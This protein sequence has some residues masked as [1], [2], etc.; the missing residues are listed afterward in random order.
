M[1]RSDFRLTLAHQVWR[2][3]PAQYRRW[4]LTSASALL[5]PR[6]DRAPPA[7]QVGVAVAGE[8][9]RASGIGEGA[10]LML[11][12]LRQASVA[13]WAMDVG[14]LLPAHTWDITSATE[15]PPPA[16]TLVLHV[17]PPLLPLVLMR[18]P[19][20]MVRGRRIV[21]YW[22]WEL[23]SAPPDWRVGARFVH[24]AWVPSAFTAGAIEPL[25]PG[26]V[27]VVPH[28]VAAAPPVASILDRTTFGL[29]HNAVIVLVSLNLASSFERK[30]PLAA[31]AAFRSAFGDRADRILV[32]KV[33][34][35]QHFP[36]DFARIVDAASGTSNI[37]L[38]TRFLPAAD[39]HALTI[40]CDIVLSM[41]RSEGFGLMLAEAMLLGRPVVAT[42]WSGNMTFMDADC[43]ALIDY[44]LVAT[45]DPR[46]V[47]IDGI[48]AEPDLGSAIAQLR[49]LA[50]DPAARAHI[51]AKGRAAAIK[52][53]NAEPLLAALR[54]AQ[55]T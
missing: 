2:L 10:R 5:A 34:N 41:H 37:R 29:P 39:L 33:A 3:L 20:N 49:Q 53:L 11:G 21:G 8:L 46:M 35:S 28:P 6:I 26:R 22:A 43:A 47:Y 13:S 4:A 18:L 1:D 25:L 24:E 27:R 52:R 16:T 40:A 14:P 54:E 9:S 45:H 50:K 38:E 36:A 17:N 15:T 31:I 7:Q 48:W 44:R 30:N 19:R 23:P 32:V 12:A 42:G 55:V 51:G